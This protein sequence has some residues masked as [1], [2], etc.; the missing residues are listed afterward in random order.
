MDSVMPPMHV[1]PNSTGVHLEKARRLLWTTVM[2]TEDYDYC[3]VSERLS[4]GEFP[5]R[6]V[7]ITGTFYDDD[8]DEDMVYA[9]VRV[10]SPQQQGRENIMRALGDAEPLDVGWAYH[11]MAGYGLG[12]EVWSLA[13]MRATYEIY[14]AMITACR[15][16]ADAIESM[17]AFYMDRPLNRIGATGWD[18]VR[19]DLWPRKEEGDE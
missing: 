18:L 17:F 1:I 6:L 8:R 9:G 15:D 2:D 11:L 12:A 13:P 7:V 3:A 16:E 19:G 4:N 5:Y 14:R 10:V